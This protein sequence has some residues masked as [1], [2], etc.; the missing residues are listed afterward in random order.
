MA[1]HNG[2][3]SWSAWRGLANSIGA[4]TIGPTITDEQ[5][6]LVRVERAQ[7]RHL[8]RGATD[9][10]RVVSAW[11]E[12]RMSRR[13]LADVARLAVLTAIYF[14]SGKL[15]LTLAYV[16]VSA[17]AVWPPADMP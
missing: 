11:L 15:G 17:S 3:C 14:I 10:G 2:S 5:P 4:N 8:Q 16:N 6:G 12:E 13:H 1:V 9:G 7:S